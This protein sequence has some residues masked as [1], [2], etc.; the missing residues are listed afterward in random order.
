MAKHEHTVE[1]AGVNLAGRNHGW[2]GSFYKDGIDPRGEKAA[3][4]VD[5]ENWEEHLKGLA[6]AGINVQKRERA[7]REVIDTIPAAVWSALPDGSNT[8]VN[9]R[10]VEYSGLSAEQAAGS[11]WQAATHPGDLQQHLSKWMA[12]VATGEPFA[13]EV[14]FRRADGE[15]RWHS[16][17][18][19][20]LRDDEGRIVRW[21]GILFDIDELKKTESALQAREH[22]L[23]GIIETIP[24][25]LWS[26]SPTGE[27]THLSQRCVEYCGV[28]L[29]ELVNRGWERFIHPDDREAT[30]KAFA[31]AIETGESYSSI[32]RL[33]R[34]DGEYRWHHAMGEP[35]RD[36]HGK[37]IQWYGLAIDIDER[38]RAEA[39]LAG[40]K[41][42][43]EMIVSGCSLHDVL[44]ALC[45]FVEEAAPDCYCGVYPIDWSGP[46]FQYGVAPSLPS[47]YIEPIKGLPVRCDIAPCGIAAFRKTQV[48][49]TDIESDPLWHESDYRTHVL[50]HG[51]RSVWSTPIY[52]L[53]GPVLGTFCIYQRKAG[54]PTRAHQDLIGQVTHIASIAIERAQAEAALKRS[55]AL[56]AAGQGLSLTGTF[57]WRVATDEIIWSEQLYRIFDFETTV[58]VTLE[59]I[60]ARLH[61]EDLSLFRET[62]NRVRANGGDFEYEHRLQMPDNSVKYLHVVAH[63]NRD[64]DAR[65]EYIGAI[66][67]VTDRRRSEAALAELAHINRV[68]TLGEMA[69]SLAHE[70]KQPIAA[71]IT[72]ANSC[73]EWLAH[74]PP[75]LDRARAAAA[76]IDKYGNRAA[77]I[78][79]RIRSLYKKSAPQRELVDVNGIVEE[80]LTLLKGEVDRYSVSVRTELA[81]KLPEITVD[82]VQLQQVFMNL[83]LNAIEAM[84]DSGGQLTVKSELEDGQLQFSVRDTGVGLPADKMD[85]IFSAFFTTKP[86]GSGMG[87]AISRS[88]VESHSGRLWATANDGRGATFHFTLP[89]QVTESSPLVA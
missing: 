81:A 19:V 27:T 58:P 34:A 80:M 4:I 2:P 9:K 87:L 45:R 44:V 1:L 47:T 82:R 54:K 51:L 67:D 39:Q 14:R 3:Q 41:Q 86:Q 72:S 26:V 12:S 21:Y 30:M 15:Y 32:H 29:D 68:S 73:V 60:A 18:G 10:F 85:Q 50:T 36:P 64:T 40:E 61:P 83:V 77:E 28:P 37:I 25:M 6:E 7:L 74:E 48:I 89:I 31:R 76:R 20:P 84:K 35:L 59:R 70:I 71:A 33:R 38:K 13:N 43:L 16:C 24:S 79:D 66:Q 78:I 23:L 53:E 42:L 65:L 69:A 57:F 22:E 88:I 63:G 56:L 62:T 17:R 11:S 46:T 5:P 52:S 75:N 8:Y 55:E 49:V